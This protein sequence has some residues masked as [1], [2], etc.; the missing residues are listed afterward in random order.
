MFHS[1]A[2][3]ED[4][5]TYVACFSGTLLD[6]DWAAFDAALVACRSLHGP[7]NVLLDFGGVEKVEISCEQIVA[8]GWQQSLMPGQQRVIVANNALFGLMRMYAAYQA[9][10]GV[11]PIIVRTLSEAYEAL[12]LT[13]LVKPKGAP[14]DCEGDV[15]LARALNALYPI[16]PA[17]DFTGL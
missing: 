3:H 5:H 13:H 9:H 17:A 1:F 12:G 7:A 14:I 11:M 2:F 6:E 10:H 15:A 16:E 8:R 4:T